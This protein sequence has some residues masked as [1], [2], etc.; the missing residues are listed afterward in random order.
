MPVA[1]D[2]RRRLAPE[3]RK[4]L[5]LT[6]AVE[7]FSRRGIGR[8]GHTDIAELGGVSVATVF[9]YFKT[10]DSLV[11]SVLDEIARFMLAMAEEAFTAEATPLARIRDYFQRFLQA[12]EEQP[13]YIKVWLEWSASPRE[14]VWP[15]YL[16]LQSELLQQL[17][18]QIEAAIRQGEL[19]QGLAATERARWLWGNSQM[20]TGMMFDPQG[21]P[22]D[23]HRIVDQALDHLLRVKHQRTEKTAR[24]ATAAMTA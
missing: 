4:R 22:D 5:L 10:R 7:V 11:I 3:E 15:R 6:H 1:V 18:T 14:V 16:T 2:G 24:P 12:C 20:L 23:I 8:G 9:N 17:S 21:K 13:D 19:E